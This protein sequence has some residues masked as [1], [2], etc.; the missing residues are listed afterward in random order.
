VIW[1]LAVGNVLKILHKVQL[2]DSLK[3]MHPFQ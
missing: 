1:A 3:W 2:T